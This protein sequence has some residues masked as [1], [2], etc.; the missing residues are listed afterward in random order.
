MF[1]PLINNLG[2]RGIGRPLSKPRERE[3]LRV[4]QSPWARIVFSSG[5]ILLAFSLFFGAAPARAAAEAPTVESISKRL[6]D[7]CPDCKGKL[8]AGCECGGA[9]KAKAEIA[10][11]LKQGKSEEEVM[12]D[13]RRRYGEWILAVPD[14]K[15]FNIL[16]FLL[17]A[18]LIAGGAG[19][20]VLF[21]RRAVLPTSRGE[22]PRPTRAQ[23]SPGGSA[24]ERARLEAELRNLDR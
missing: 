7:P 12:A 17:P 21:L 20:I 6:M 24:R 9:A 18:V 22:T 23:P 1:T 11:L 14:Q 4:G 15:G 5:L 16:S 19:G 3:R 10:D 13:F 8:L 2:G